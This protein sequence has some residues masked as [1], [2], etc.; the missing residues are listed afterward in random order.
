MSI[1]LDKMSSKELQ[2]LIDDAQAALVARKKLDK[3]DALAAAQKAAGEFG[4]ALDE[5]VGKG[6][7]G[8]TKASAAPKYC[9]P[10]DPSKTWTGKGRQ[11]DWFKAAIAA[12]VSEDSLLVN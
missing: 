2:Q 5:L 3:K 9:S 12:G 10:D 7:K 6:G 8:K 1:K 11:P 4:F